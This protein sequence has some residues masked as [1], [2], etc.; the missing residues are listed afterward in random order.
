MKTMLVTGTSQ[1]IGLAIIKHFC[2]D[3]LIVSVDQNELDF[4]H[5]NITHLKY[6][7]SDLSNIKSL[8]IKPI[9][10]LI[11]NAAISN[12]IPYHQVDQAYYQMF[13]NV[14]LNAP[15]FLS[16]YFIEQLASKGRIVNIAS[17]RALMMEPHNELYSQ[18]KAGMLAQTSAF[19]I[20]TS[21]LD[22]TVNA[23]SPGWIQNSD[24][25]K[26]TIQ[27]HTQHPSNRVGKPEDIIK[28]IQYLIDED[29][30]FINGQNIIVDGGMTKKMIYT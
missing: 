14:N 18:C 7:L 24:Y 9:D 2:E 20:S 23:I 28:A 27:D 17:T 4:N 25:D 30:D 26:L 22:L 3:Y 19:A 1:G 13:M 5:P 10:I 29:N 11:N 16:K 21:S 8:F 6:D 15:Y 12:F